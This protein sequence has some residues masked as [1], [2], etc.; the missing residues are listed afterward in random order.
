MGRSKSQRKNQAAKKFPYAHRAQSACDF[1]L[2]LNQGLLSLNK[3]QSPGER[4]K[5]NVKLSLELFGSIAT[6]DE[7]G[8]G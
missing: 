3:T 7:Q 8:L 2:N 5:H 6:G 4:G 1:P